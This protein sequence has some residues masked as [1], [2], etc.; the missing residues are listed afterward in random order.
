MVMSQP[1]GTSC[2]FMIE[3]LE[4]QVEIMIRVGKC[5]ETGNEEFG[6]GG[7]DHI[8]TGSLIW[9]NDFEDPLIE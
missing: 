2:H 7:I 8:G 5:N 4:N 9:R 3:V 6:G 1:L